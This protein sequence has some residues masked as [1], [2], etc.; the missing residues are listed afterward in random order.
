MLRKA[1]KN[2]DFFCNISDPPIVYRAEWQIKRPQKNF[3][4]RLQHFAVPDCINSE[5]QKHANNERT[6]F[7]EKDD[8]Y[9]D[10]TGSSRYDGSTGDGG[11]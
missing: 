8:F 4:K 11:K 6:I 7:Y 10:G 5:R 1:Q 3:L 9:D 2:F